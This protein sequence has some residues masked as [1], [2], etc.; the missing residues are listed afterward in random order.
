MC[1]KIVLTI[2]FFHRSIWNSIKNKI[3]YA[4]AHAQHKIIYAQTI[5]VVLHLS[6]QIFILV[7][8]SPLVSLENTW[9]I[10][11]KFDLSAC[12]RH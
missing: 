3:L 6:V 7:P 9:R 12:L 5:S 10:H 8:F 11:K 2:L 4:G 1:T